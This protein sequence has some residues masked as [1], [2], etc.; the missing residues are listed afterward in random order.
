MA[1]DRRDT[2]Y[3][4]AK[5]EGY[6]SRAAYKL[7]Q[8]NEKHEVIKEDDTIVDLGAAPGGWLEV[9]KKISGGKIVGV[10]LRRIKEIEGVETI[11]GDITSDET[12]KK[13]I[14][15][16][17]EGGA[18]VV[19]CD[20]APNLSGNWSLDHARSIDLTTSALECAKKILKPKGHFIVKVFQGDMFKEYMD[21]VR[22]SFTYTRAFSPKAS[23]PESAEIYV[24]GKKLLTAPLKIDDKFD[25]T[26]KK[27]GAKGNG[28]AFVEDF[29]VFM[30][31]EV[32]KGENVRIKIVD[33]KPEFA[34]AI[35]IGRYDE[36]LNEKNEE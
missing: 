30:Q 13:I 4:R 6:R 15:L 28:I 10:D 18:D 16:V 21:K 36:E 1:R 17:G 20:A 11:K 19:I 32:K 9:A 35:V 12:I 27:I 29:V 22:E 34:F 25:V 23:R 7:F 24:I 3:W 8:I 31:D 26:I 5:D 2:Y 33:V 14:E